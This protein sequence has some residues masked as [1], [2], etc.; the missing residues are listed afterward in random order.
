MNVDN[1][2]VKDLDYTSPFFLYLI[3]SSVNLPFFPCNNSFCTIH[4]IPSMFLLR[5][6]ESV[7]VHTFY[8]NKQGREHIFTR[9]NDNGVV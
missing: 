4:A 7:V 6:T 8:H 1:H 2:P 5:I 9:M 3:H